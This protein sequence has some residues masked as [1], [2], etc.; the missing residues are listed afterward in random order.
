[1]DR[2]LRKETTPDGKRHHNWEESGKIHFGYL[3]NVLAWSVFLILRAVL[4]LFE[5][6]LGRCRR[7]MSFFLL[8]TFSFVEMAP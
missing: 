5:R 1:M 4:A 8:D 6:P 3:P 7:G 2:M